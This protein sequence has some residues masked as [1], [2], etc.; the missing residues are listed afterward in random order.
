MAKGEP[1]VSWAKLQRNGSFPGVFCALRAMSSLGTLSNNMLYVELT[2]ISPES[3]GSQTEVPLGLL[4][5]R[6]ALSPIP[7]SEET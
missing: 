1:S 5:L 4:H 3:N 2:S 6:F 7:N